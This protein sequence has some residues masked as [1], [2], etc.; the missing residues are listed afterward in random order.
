[1][2]PLSPKSHVYWPSL[3]SLWSRF[4]ELSEM[5]SSR[6]GYSPYFAPNKILLKTL[7]LCF[8]FQST[9]AYEAWL[10]DTALLLCQTPLQETCL[11][12]QGSSTQCVCV[13]VCVRESFSR[14]QLFVTSCT[15]AHQASL[16]M[17]FSRQEYW[18][19]LPLPS[20]EDLPDPEIEPLSP[21]LQA[22]S[23]LFELQGS[24][25]A[26]SAHL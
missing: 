12:H 18:S 14:V 20:P 6:L 4:S 7:T 16:S 1:M 3:L 26:L 11:G 25:S 24:P 23:L 21:A 15:I 22:D 17:E 5:L 8:S 9:L 19:G 2:Y 10:Y 13:C